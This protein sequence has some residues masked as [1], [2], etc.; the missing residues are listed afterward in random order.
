MR[1]PKANDALRLDIEWRAMPR[2]DPTKSVD[3]VIV[4]RHCAGY[5]F[6]H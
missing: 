2:P 4:G 3:D 1:L 5:I 6:F